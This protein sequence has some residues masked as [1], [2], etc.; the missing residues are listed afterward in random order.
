[1][2]TFDAWVKLK[3]GH[4]YGS[5]PR[6]GKATGFAQEATRMRTKRGVDR[7]FAGQSIP[8]TASSECG[9]HDPYSCRNSP[10]RVRPPTRPTRSTTRVRVVPPGALV[11]VYRASVDIYR[12]SVDI[13]RASGDIYRASGDIYRASGDVYRAL[14]D[15]YRALVDVYRASVDTD[16]SVREHARCV[17]CAK[18]IGLSGGGGRGGRECQ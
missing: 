15:V 4:V 13:Y 14:V 8:R 11:D 18:T 2:T 3:I 5:K 12:A 16:T 17:N 1:M 6:R 10:R 7:E 9:C